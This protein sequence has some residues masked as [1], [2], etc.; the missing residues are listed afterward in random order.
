[1]GVGLTVRIP[2][3]RSI[4]GV[5][6][7]GPAVTVFTER[8]FFYGLGVRGAEIGVG[9]LFVEHREKRDDEYYKVA[10]G[11]GPAL[12]LGPYLALRPWKQC[13]LPWSMLCDTAVRVSFASG[14]V[15]APLEY[16]R[17][18]DADGDGISDKK[19][20]D[21]FSDANCYVSRDLAVFGGW[22]TGLMW[23]F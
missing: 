22:S 7:A 21:T 17:T 2:R 1:M 10:K 15:Y 16:A 11:S 18:W 20:G 13:K 3:P 23:L 14:V 19:K 8:E 5:G 9:W 12:V 4:P 6:F